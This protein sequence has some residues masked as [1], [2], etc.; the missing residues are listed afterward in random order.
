MNHFKSKLRATE[1]TLTLTNLAL[2]SH[3]PLQQQSRKQ[4][5]LKHHQSQHQT[6]TT[7]CN[8]LSNNTQ[9]QKTPH[10]VCNNLFKPQ[11]T[12]INHARHKSIHQSNMIINTMPKDT[13]LDLNWTISSLSLTHGISMA[14]LIV[15][16]NAQINSH[17][18]ICAH[19]VFQ[20]QNPAD[21]NVSE[22]T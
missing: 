14:N 8:K 12:M 5:H 18:E 4:R 13:W 10:Q 20:R 22:S 2:T 15:T 1:S 17:V 21:C 6:A 11:A 9:V 7:M 3:Q 16:G 19:T